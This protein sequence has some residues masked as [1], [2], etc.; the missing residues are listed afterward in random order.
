LVIGRDGQIRR[1]LIGAQTLAAF[2]A[3]IGR[4]R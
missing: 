3:A 1:M 4:G 2:E